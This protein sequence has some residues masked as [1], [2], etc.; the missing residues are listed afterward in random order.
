MASFCAIIPLF[1]KNY[2]EIIASIQFPLCDELLFQDRSNVLD[3]LCKRA[4]RSVDLFLSWWVSLLERVV[5]YLNLFVHSTA[6]ARTRVWSI[7]YLF[8]NKCLCLFLLFRYDL[9][10]FINGLLY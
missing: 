1:C 8:A 10:L 2:F 6:G 9:H 5:K 4:V 7:G 3:Y